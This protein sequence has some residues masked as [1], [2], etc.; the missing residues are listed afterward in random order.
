MSDGKVLIICI[1]VFVVGYIFGYFGK[2]N[3]YHDS[4]NDNSEDLD[5]HI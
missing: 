4:R 2:A 5:Y 3:E 1:V